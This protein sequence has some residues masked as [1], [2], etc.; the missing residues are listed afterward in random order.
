MHICLA[1]KR[2]K[3]SI[4]ADIF[5]L[6]VVVVLLN[7]VIEFNLEQAVNYEENKEI[8]FAGLKH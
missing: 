2:S 7:S 8:A 4:D 1:M 6:R 5:M 3:Y